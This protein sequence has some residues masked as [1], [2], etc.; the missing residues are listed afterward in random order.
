[1]SDNN[2][3]PRP[4]AKLPPT[5]FAQTIA[6]ALAER[7]AGREQVVKIGTPATGT[8]AGKLQ[9]SEIALPRDPDETHE[10]FTQRLTMVARDVLKIC[11]VL[12]D[13]NYRDELLREALQEIRNLEK[14]TT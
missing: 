11:L 3:A 14:V 5:A 10:Q 13:E 2:E 1:M 6:Q 7:H 9:L 12:N 8:L 4:D